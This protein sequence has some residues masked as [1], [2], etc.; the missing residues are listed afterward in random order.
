MKVRY[1]VSFGK[2]FSGKP[3]KRRSRRATVDVINDMS[4]DTRRQIREQK[5]LE[6]GPGVGGE[7]EGEDEGESTQSSSFF[8]LEIER[9]SLFL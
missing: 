9:R 2:Y 7:G 4:M 5:S 3:G 1:F 8:L 6:F